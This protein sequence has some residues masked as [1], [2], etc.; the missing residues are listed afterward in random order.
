MC[1]KLDTFDRRKPRIFNK[2]KL[3]K[4]LCKKRAIY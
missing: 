3:V 1:K 4:I 2:K